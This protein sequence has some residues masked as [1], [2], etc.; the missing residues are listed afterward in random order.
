MKLGT[1]WF[2]QTV[3]FVKEPPNPEHALILFL[4]PDKSQLTCLSLAFTEFP[5]STGVAEPAQACHTQSLVK[6]FSTVNKQ[7]LQLEYAH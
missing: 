5:F 4:I 1:F 6:I 7:S 3:G 2:L